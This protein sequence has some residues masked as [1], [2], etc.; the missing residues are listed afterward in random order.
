[1]SG[2]PESRLCLPR[3]SPPSTDSRIKSPRS[4]TN[5]LSAADT[6]VSVSAMRLRHMSS[7]LVAVT[8]GE[9]SAQFCDP[10]FIWRR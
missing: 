6:G 5:S 3:V 9:A 1:M 2:M 8:V 10:V 7:G 4:G